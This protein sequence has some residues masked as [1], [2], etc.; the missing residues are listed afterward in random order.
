MVSVEMKWFKHDTCAN[1]DAK[2]KRVRMK[3]GME[4]YG[5]YWY[6][7]E[8]VAANVTP[9]NITFEL[10]HDAEVI[11][12]DTGIHVERVNEMIA[13]MVELALFEISENT[14]TCLKIAKRLDKSMTSNPEMRR[15]IDGL[16]NSHDSVMTPSANPMQDKNR[17]DKN[18]YIS[19][20][21][22]NGR[23]F[24]PP[25]LSEV[26]Q[27]ID[28]KN[29][30]VDAERFVN[31]YEAKNWMIGKNKM[32]KWKAALANWHKSNREQPKRTTNAD[33]HFEAIRNL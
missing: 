23:R 14:I 27:Y 22:N 3:Y 32:R 5:L 2:L 8:L 19:N 30:S 16:R 4:G 26:Q 29:Y 11:A 33:K 28:E 17:L 1:H 25:T 6:C 9:E 24:T 10:E 7:L 13:Y 12:F 20:I 15:V 31:F 18:R 21:G